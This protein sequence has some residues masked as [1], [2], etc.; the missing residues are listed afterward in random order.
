MD[1][2]GRNSDDLDMVRSWLL[3]QGGRR[4]LNPMHVV[5]P[6]IAVNVSVPYEEARRLPDSPFLRT[7][8]QLH[9]T[10]AMGEGWRTGVTWH[11]RLPEAGEGDGSGMGNELIPLETFTMTRFVEFTANGS[12]SFIL[13]SQARDGRIDFIKVQEIDG[14]RNLSVIGTL[15]A[16]TGA[17]KKKFEVVLRKGCPFCTARNRI[18]DCAPNLTQQYFKRQLMARRQKHKVLSP[19]AGS[20]KQYIRAWMEGHWVIRTDGKPTLSMFLKVNHSEEILRRCLTYVLQ[21]DEA[22]IL[23]PTGG[24]LSIEDSR[25]SVSP[26][27]SSTGGSKQKMK[28]STGS[29]VRQEEKKKSYSCPICHASIK[30]K[31]DVQRH[32]RTVHERIRNHQCTLCPQAFLQS[33]HLKDHMRGAHA[34]TSENMCPRCGKHFGMSSKLKRHVAAVHENV[35]NFRC[36]KC[37]KTYKDNK[38]L[39]RHVQSKHSPAA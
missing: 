27:S 2:L 12:V 29:T 28:M 39:K 30:R 4:R 7:G 24:L 26:S 31:F 33:S 16:E 14:G 15:D 17:M 22:Q 37:E 1:L 3:F 20:F 32:I 5:S 11:F 13:T 19:L 25:L 8:S 23:K 38:S 10:E 35:R 21:I 9:L 34:D 18:C 6:E 36:Q